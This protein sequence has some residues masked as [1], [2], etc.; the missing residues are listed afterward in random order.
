MNNIAESLSSVELAL[1]RLHRQELLDALQPGLPAEDV[2]RE[3]TNVGLTGTPAL[4]SL[5]GWHNGTAAWA[6]DLDSIHVFP[7]Y[8]MPPL[9]EA[10]ANYH[11]FKDDARWSAGWLPIFADGG[12]DFY[13]IDLRDA[14]ASIRGFRIDESEHPVEFETLDDM[15][16][17][18]A[19]AFDEGI[20]FL[21]RENGYLDAD[22]LAF[23]ELAARLNS[24]VPYWQR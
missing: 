21:D 2:H 24:R 19:T 15:L 10:I 23:A 9:D 13:V 17:T 5:Y 7:G 22:D 1:S 18:I 16:R 3:L 6:D 4:E 11:T 12:G 20:Y 14:A 8:Y